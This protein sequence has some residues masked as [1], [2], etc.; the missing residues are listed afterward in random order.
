MS[1]AEIVTIGIISTVIGIVLIT[2]IIW[3]VKQIAN[4]SAATAV[5]TKKADDNAVIV[6]KLKK[7]GEIT[8]SSADL[9]TVLDRLRDLNK[10]F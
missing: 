6:E 2:T 3:L 10:E 1:L 9:N 4:Q 8:A 5:A 7:A